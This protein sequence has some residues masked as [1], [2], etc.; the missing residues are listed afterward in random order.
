MSVPKLLVVLILS[1]L[2]TVATAQLRDVTDRLEQASERFRNA[3][4]EHL[5][6]SSGDAAAQLIRESD[7]L[8]NLGD[9]LKEEV[10]RSGNPRVL[11]ARAAETFDAM[12]H[13][14]NRISSL[15]NQISSST[16]MANE[17]NNTQRLMDQIKSGGSAVAKSSSAA[18]AGYGGHVDQIEDAA[19]R[20]K[21]AFRDHMRQHGQ[22]KSKGWATALS[23]ALSAFDQD[24]NALRDSFRKRN[25][26]NDNIVARMKNRAKAISESIDTQTV[27]PAARSQWQ[28]V[29]NNLNRL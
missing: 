3:A 1:M 11:N 10:R 4:K 25:V 5:G 27:G 8:E 28:R 13:R 6:N 22:L 20:T 16:R 19:E 15:M 18:P 14:R 9:D 17:W 21:N 24:A 29:M 12:T 26:K 23:G 2:S 7:V